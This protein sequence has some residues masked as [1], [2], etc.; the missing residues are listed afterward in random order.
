[1]KEEIISQFSLPLQAK[2]RYGIDLLRKTEKLAFKYDP[3]D[4]FWLAFSGGKDSQALYHLA[5][6]A[7][8]KFRAHMSMTSVDPPE[9]V[10]FVK[11]NYPD[12]VRHAPKMSIYAD[13]VKRKILPTMVVRWCC[14]DF[15]ESAGAGKV[16]LIGIR[17]AESARC[18]KRHEIEVN[19]YKF[20]GNLDEFYQ[21]QQQ[22]TAKIL[23]KQAKGK[24][25]NINEDEFTAKPNDVR[26]ISGKE[27]ILVSPV[28][29]WSD[30]DVWEFLN[31]LD[32]P[33]C[34]LYDQ[35]YTRIG[36][37][38]CPMS[39]HS[40][41]LRE[42]QRWPHVKQKWIEAIKLIRMGGSQQDATSG[43]LVQQRAV[44]EGYLWWGIPKE[45]RQPQIPSGK[46]LHAKHGGQP[47]IRESAGQR[48]HQAL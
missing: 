28:F 17:A 1:M 24:K 22:Q 43:T 10:R 41:K 37:I 30:A 5:K 39:Q 33:H 23:A 47:R 35:G 12:V 15:K 48:F 36:C 29:R 13:A 16:T 32:V 42:I 20:S 9:V 46:Q 8:V 11:R 3:E 34:E 4:G 2:I 14:A 7:G 44:A 25:A 38:L 27:S 6:L 21:W 19:S 26:C 45:G 18:A 31:K 40:Q